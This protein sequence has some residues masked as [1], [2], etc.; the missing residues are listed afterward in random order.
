MR[1]SIENESMQTGVETT[2]RQLREDDIPGV[3]AL[4]ATVFERPGRPQPSTDA[5][6]RG[7]IRYVAERDAKIVGFGAARSYGS[8]AY[9][10]PMAVHP[11]LRRQGI[12]SNLLRNLIGSLERSNCST[13]L[14]DATESGAQLYERY[15]FVG[16]DHSDV[17]ERV[18][19]GLCGADSMGIDANELMRAAAIDRRIAG[20]DRRAALEGFALESGAW[21]ALQ[22]GGFALTHSRVL[23]PWLA[24]SG[25]EAHE[26]FQAA[27]AACPEVDRIFVPRSNREARQIVVTAG[28][29]SSRSLL[30]M[31]RG[32]PSP[33]KRARIF[34]QGSLAHG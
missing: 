15:G 3:D 11:S 12:A 9:I 10:G 26:L 27:M 5:S 29:R 2:I 13:L 19:D 21:L 28:F 16:L 8:V 33:M 20:C 25:S 17:Y 23:G 7:E 30:H 22:N 32:K 6:P 34:G 24:D 1:P 31:G 18:T 14:L 4:I